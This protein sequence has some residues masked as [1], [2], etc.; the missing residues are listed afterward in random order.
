VGDIEAFVC[1]EITLPLASEGMVYV[2]GRGFG[3]WGGGAASGRNWGGGRLSSACSRAVKLA[4]W[5]VVIRNTFLVL[6][7]VP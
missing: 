1:K 2:G 5:L 6:V 3:T 7:A 4:A